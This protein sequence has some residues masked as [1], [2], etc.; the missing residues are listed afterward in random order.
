MLVYPQS[1]TRI[2][3]HGK[4]YID[5]I[6]HLLYTYIYIPITCILKTDGNMSLPPQRSKSVLTYLAGG[7]PRH[8]RT[9]SSSSIRGHK[10]EKSQSKIGTPVDGPF[11]TYTSKK[12][13]ADES[14]GHR[15]HK[16]SRSLDHRSSYRSNRKSYQAEPRHLHQG[17]Y[18]EDSD[19]DSPM[20]RSF[21]SRAASFIDDRRYSHASPDEQS[22][23]SPVSPLEP[24]WHREPTV[25][26]ANKHHIAPGL[27]LKHWDPD[28]E[29]IM[30]LTSVFDSYSLGKWV[31]DQTAR[32]YGEHDE[33]TDLAA[34]FWLEHIKLGGKIKHAKGRMPQ[35]ADEGARQRVKE[36]TTSGD[37]IVNELGEALKGCE[38]RV[39][40]VT[41]IS[42]I[43][44]LS[45]KSVVVFIDTFIGRNPAQRDAFDN[46]T[47]SIREWNCWFDADC[48]RLLG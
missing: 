15:R 27:C 21:F 5:Y 2:K 45:H 26:D 13:K 16:S 39:L 4:F 37:K 8:T 38:Q 41:G 6:T 20:E 42:E 35:I 7:T 18:F 17:S 24:P 34:D 36:F 33:M 32:I 28:Q 48:E 29:P 47:R 22:P 46:L 23:I 30:L 3:P 11:P 19:S 9:S 31:L 12:A 14:K 25:A 10:S 43:P 1:K 44:K 40:E